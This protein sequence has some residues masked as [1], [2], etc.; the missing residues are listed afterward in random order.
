[1]AYH[2]FDTLTLND[3]G[4]LIFTPCPGTKGVNLSDSVT[5]LKEAGVNM[6]ITL[7]DDEELTTHNVA[8]LQEYVLVKNMTWLQLPIVDDEGPSQVFEERWRIHKSEIF[9]LLKNQGSAAVHCKGGTG[10]TGLVIGLILLELGYTKAQALK[11]VQQVRPK[12]LINSLQRS[13][14]DNY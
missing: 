7:L 11:L 10:R 12:A 14:F 1:M 3:G 2:P 5:Q 13:Y 9:Q 6:V 4:K 8:Q